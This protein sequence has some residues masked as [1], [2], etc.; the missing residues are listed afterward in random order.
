MSSY[1]HFQDDNF[2]YSRESSRTIADNPAFNS[3]VKVS[4]LKKDSFDE[5]FESWVEFLQ[6]ARWFPDLFY[7]LIKPEKGGM[8]LDLDQRVFL[9]CMSRFIST[10]GVFPRGFG[11]TMIELMSIYHSC[12]FF[13]DINIAMSAQTKENAASISEDKHK[14]LVKKFPLLQNE[15]V[16]ASFSKDNAEVI[17]KSGATYSILANAQ[18]TKGQ[19]RHRLNIEESALLNNE[20]FKDALEPV[21]NVPRRTIGEM[22]VIS[23]FELN[24]MINFVTTS[25]YRGSDE[26]NRILNMI[27]E[28][29][30]LK[31]KMVLGASWEL[32]CH[33]GRGETRNQLLAK[34]NDPT[35]SATAFAMNYESKWV[36]A[37]DGAL[38]NISKL[39]KI[40]TLDK[41]ELNCPKDKRGNFELN[42]YIF[43]VDVARS[44]SQSNN[45]T[46]IVVLKIIR[47]KTGTIRQIQAVNIVEPP[48]G[49]SFKEQS[50]IVKRLFYAYGGHSDILKSRVK[51]IV[52]DGNVI[53]KGLIDRLLED[54]TDPDTNEELGCFDTIN[55]D[56]KPDVTPAIEVV[57]DLTAQGINGEIIRTFIDYV[58]TEK[59]KL[60]KIND[61]IKG[62]SV[63]SNVNLE[64]DKARIHTQYLI[65]EISNL[66]LESTQKSITVKQVLKK[67]D[68]DRY[69]ALAYALY[70]IFLFLEKEEVEEVYDE[71]DSLV[72]F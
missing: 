15:I 21:V 65:D 4:D 67:I 7:D 19:R 22:S 47:N 34:K 61:E 32:P 9:R 66:K 44:N 58:E 68:K 3:Q 37:T 2:K 51:A 8:R 54:L 48:N 43:G 52:V 57:Y 33:Y 24:G 18:S 1:K 10:Y 38:V 42:E 71:D 6:W 72:Y 14:E 45:K 59:L 29:A 36:G 25:G 30:N 13:A 11:K 70:Y 23:P 40:R 46:A 12:I 20:L 31:G 49:L 35:T 55:T 56:Q 62:K 27:K 17:F 60:L 5:N 16:K 64:E 53:G 41:P 69:S 39:L 63:N 28:T 26:F 50:L